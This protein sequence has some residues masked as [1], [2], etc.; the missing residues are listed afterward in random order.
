MSKVSITVNDRAYAIGC[1]PGQEE[2]VRRL[3]AD[4][5]ARVAE[6]TRQVGQIG[7]LRLFLMAAL[8][9]ADELQEITDRLHSAEARAR[10]LSSAGKDAGE[11]A[12]REVAAVRHKAAQALDAAA[13]QV[14]EILQSL[15]DQGLAPGR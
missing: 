6:L 7:D 12:G 5:D 11:N 3:G 2:Q 13:A 8:T 9:M 4:F 10:S 1:E 15:D 14:E